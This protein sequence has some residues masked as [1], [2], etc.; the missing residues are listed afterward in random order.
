MGVIIFPCIVKNK[1]G[2]LSDK[3][4]YAELQEK[5]ENEDLAIITMDDEYLSKPFDVG[6]YS[7]VGQKPCVSISYGTYDDFRCALEDM[8]DETE[9]YNGG[10]N[11]TLT[12]GGIDN[13]VS[14]KIAEEMLSEFEAH[15]ECAKD[16]FYKRFDEDYGEFIWGN[17]KR[18]IDVLKEC[19]KV[20]G[21]VRYY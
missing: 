19:C 20:K 21:V 1:I 2:E 8:E 17:Y 4:K 15:L 7:A 3:D 14:Y 10:F 6:Y 9:S 18:Y 11:T 5:C 16:Y 13:C 12:S